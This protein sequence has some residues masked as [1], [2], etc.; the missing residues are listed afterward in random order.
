MGMLNNKMK[1]NVIIKSKLN[2]PSANS[3][4]TIVELLV[5]IVVIGI[6]AAITTISYTGISQK[7]IVTSLQSDLANASEQI[8]IFQARSPAGNYPTAINCTNPT[9]TEICIKTSD[10]NSLIPNNGYTVNN[11]ANPKYFSI[12]AN[13][14]TTTYR[15]TNDST[16]SSYTSLATTDPDNWIA[17]GNQVWARA[18]LNVG[19]RING[20]VNQTNNG[21]TNVVEKYCYNDL[22][23]DCTTYGGLYQWDEA[24]QYVTT[25]GAQG[26][27]PVGSHIPSDNDWKI[28]E[29]QLGMSQA[30]AD[31]TGWRG[32]DQGAQLKNN[33]ASGLDM[34]L[35]GYRITNGTFNLELI[36]AV[37]WTSSESANN[38][39]SHHLTISFPTVYRQIHD[40]INGLSVRCIG[41]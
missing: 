27:C 13:N 10:S 28:L 2:L 38:A 8:Q 37:L 9:S 3:A 36:N 4:F 34:S 18:N 33:G 22:E 1:H 29:M 41:N 39:W 30:Q 7:A 11:S 25:N 23:S 5:V 19:T 20:A 21:G 6:L 31:T 24:M 26:I 16:P 32:T 35:A 40:K 14:N 15:T 12:I 17:I